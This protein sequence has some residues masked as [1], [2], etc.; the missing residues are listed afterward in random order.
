MKKTLPDAADLTRK[1]L[2]GVDDNWYQTYWCREQ[3]VATS[4]LPAR[5]VRSAGKWIVTTVWRLAG[6]LA[7]RVRGT[8]DLSAQP[9]ETA[10]D[11]L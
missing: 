10:R 8:G 11:Q 1:A 9:L 7:S 2:F 4:R 3:T 6:E 5:L